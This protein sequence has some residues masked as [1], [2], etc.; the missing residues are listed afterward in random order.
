VK[1]AWIIFKTTVPTKAPTNQSMLY[2]EIIAGSFE[3][4]TKHINTLCEQNTE[5]VLY[6]TAS[7]AYSCHF[8]WNS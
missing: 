2:S 5:F 7:G 1:F 4:H 8:T 3:I 6:V